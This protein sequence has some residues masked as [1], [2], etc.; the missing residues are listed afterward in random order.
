MTRIAL[1]G[2]DLAPLR[3]S[4]GALERA[5]LGWGRALELT[6]PGWKVC[7][8]E[9]PNGG[10]APAG[11]SA[12]IRRFEPD[13]VVF[14]NRPLWSES[15]EG[16][17]LH[18]LHNYP[19]AWSLGTIEEERIAAAL[20][21][22][23]VAVSPTLAREVSQRYHLAPAVG[24]VRV[25]V[26]ES[27]WGDLASWRRG[28]P[29]V[30]FPNRLLEKKGVR[31][32]L[33]IAGLLATSGLRCVMFAHT[34]PFPRPTP[35]QRDL[36]DAIAACSAVE[37]LDPPLTRLEMARWYARAGVVV[38]PSVEPEGL[39]MAALEAQAVG[40]PLVSSGLGGLRDA[41]FPPNEIVGSM[42]ASDWAD[43]IRAGLGRTPS[44]ETR[45]Q[46]RLAHGRE[47]ARASFTSAV[48]QSLRSCPGASDRSTGTMRAARR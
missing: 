6:R 36:L 3:S 44:A 5:V 16:P 34:A 45:E 10:A 43:A 18:V 26:E 30:L 23:A 25:E 8:F 28:E 32:F 37:L 20:E 1:V 42:Q 11:L 47:A 12:W 21:R 2:T 7:P 13:L 33:E 9:A 40:T 29:L 35:E 14:N 22:G 39:G 31:L 4:S 17:V 19:G 41:T 27:Y 38:C 15:V 48:E 24:E 46:V